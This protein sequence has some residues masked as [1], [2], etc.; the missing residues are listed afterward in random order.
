MLRK[1]IGLM[2][3]YVFF[4][5]CLPVFSITE[6]KSFNVEDQQINF[7]L[8]YDKGQEEWAAYA[9]AAMEKIIHSYIHYLSTSFP[10]PGKYDFFGKN[11][12]Y[13][14]QKDSA[15]NGVRIGGFNLWDRIEV[16]YGISPIGNPGLIFHETGHFWFGSD[17]HWMDEG[18]VSFLPVAMMEAGFLEL[19]EKEANEVKRHWGFW[20]NDNKKDKPLSKD[21]RG[22]DEGDRQLYY[23]KT[24]KLQYIIYKE[25]G[26][27]KYREW[28]SAY[29][30]IKKKKTDKLII[31]LLNKYKKM[32]WKK[33]LSGWVFPGKYGSISMDSFTDQDTDGLLSVEEYYLKTSPDRSDT[34]NDLLPDNFEI[35]HGLNPVKKESDDNVRK[36]ISEHGPFPDGDGREWDFLPHVFY[37]KP[38][39]G[40]KQVNFGLFSLNMSLRNG[41]LSVYAATRKPVLPRKKYMFD[42]LIDL[43]FDRNTDVEFAFWLE[44]PRIIWRYTALTRTS[45]IL[46]DLRGGRGESLEIKVPLA[47]IASVT[48]SGNFSKQP[49]KPDFQVLPIIRDDAKKKNLDEWTHW[50]PVSLDTLAG[51]ESYNLITDLETQDTDADLIPDRIELKQGLDP[52]TKDSPQTVSLYGPFVDGKPQEWY[53]F[54]EPVYEDKKNDAKVK[55]YDMLK[56]QYL[57]KKDTLFVVVITGLELKPVN[58][59]F[60][61]ILVDENNDNTSDLDFAFF[62]VNPQWPW[63]YTAKTKKSSYPQD[64]HIGLGTVIEMAIPLKEI[65]S[66]QFQILPII[67]N[68]K[69]KINYDEWDQWIQVN[70][71]K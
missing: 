42:L 19:D 29:Y 50:I 44:N 57:I 54:S 26:P 47:R 10:Q 61:D 52:T 25:L 30:L 59:V 38:K 36:M 1:I 21:F 16:E 23:S 53:L 55:G 40:E 20:F 67:R 18:L 24:F 5:I 64:I 33:F 56:L 49:G 6:D 37:I 65:N 11:E 7:T 8:H 22:Q 9:T 48:S 60:F 13:L 32:N 68:D 63:K 39:N 62:L 28:V 51:I 46:P 45:E 14:N 43:D 69:S 34:D 41:C 12:V 15:M 58:D 35:Q 17:L 27:E 31:D 3:I 2:A 4:S 71:E 66:R 70:V